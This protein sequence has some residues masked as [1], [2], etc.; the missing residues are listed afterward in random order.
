MI[1]AGSR[2]RLETF[3]PIGL[4]GAHMRGLD[5]HFQTR[6][7]LGAFRGAAGAPGI[8]PASGH[9]E[10]P[11]QQTQRILE[12]QRPHER[13]PGSCALAKYAVAFFISP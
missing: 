2:V 7:L 10:D 8:I 1:S 3:R 9:V 12:T 13:V 11:A 4:P 5:R 6:V